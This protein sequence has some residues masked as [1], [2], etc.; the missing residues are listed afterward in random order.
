MLC[1]FNRQN[2]SI[3]FSYLFLI[4]RIKVNDL[5]VE[6]FSGT[7]VNFTELGFCKKSM[8]KKSTLCFNI[9]HTLYLTAWCHTVWEYNAFQEQNRVLVTNPGKK[10]QTTHKFFN[11]DVYSNLFH[12]PRIE[13][14]NDR[15]ESCLSRLRSGLLL[16]ATVR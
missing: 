8:S 10:I 14:K 15:R 2:E 9:T 4:G 11:W 5:D 1:L 6:I 16:K 3:T 13:L 7:F 12:I